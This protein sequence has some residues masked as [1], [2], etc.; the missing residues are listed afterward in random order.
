MPGSDVTPSTLALEPQ[1]PVWPLLTAHLHCL[2][3][4]PQVYRRQA[5]M[6]RSEFM[7][8]SEGRNGRPNDILKKFGMPV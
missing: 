4:G 7:R 1:P 3:L 6:T 2:P 8:Q 5:G